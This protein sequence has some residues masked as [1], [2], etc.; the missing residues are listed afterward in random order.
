MVKLTGEEQAMLDGAK[1]AATAKAM[2]LLIRYADAL[3]AERFVET[4]NVAGV[5]GSS[6]PWVKNYYKAD[7]GDY[8]AFHF[9]IEFHPPLRR[10]NLLKYLAGPEIGGGNFLND[11]S[12]EEKAAELQTVSGVHYKS[13]APRG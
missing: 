5:P 11:T 7:G 10:P 4:N 12:P 9:H 2:E 8:R 13:E 6:I 1:G 3:G